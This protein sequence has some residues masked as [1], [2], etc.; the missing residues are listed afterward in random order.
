[1]ITIIG[2]YLT[3]FGPAIRLD[4]VIQKLGIISTMRKNGRMVL[5]FK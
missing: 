4:F 1:M 2:K 3:T 5:P